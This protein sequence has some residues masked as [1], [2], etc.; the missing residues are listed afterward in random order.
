MSPSSDASVWTF[1]KRRWFDLAAGVTILVLAFGLYRSA[2]EAQAARSEIAR[3]HSRIEAVRAEN[4]ILAAESAYLGNPRR[5]EALA[6]AKLGMKPAR[7]DQ[8]PADI[9]EVGQ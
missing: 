9:A 7:I 2:L 3:L 1:V 5:V 4:Q 6:A 8:H